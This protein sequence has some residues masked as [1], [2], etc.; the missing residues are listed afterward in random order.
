MEELK[1]MYLDILST[2][3]KYNDSEVYQVRDLKYVAECYIYWSE[4]IEK[5]GF[6]IAPKNMTNIDFMNVGQYMSIGKWGAKYK[7]TIS[8]SDDGRQPEDGEVL[9]QI[10]FPTGAYIFGDEYPSKFF[11][12]FFNELKTYKPKYIDSANKN[13]YYTMGNASEIFNNFKDI[14]NKYKEL[15]KEDCKKR[16]IAKLKEQLKSLEKE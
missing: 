13:L 12:K 8:W 7:R 1:K 4:I 2:L 16:K 9:L 3:K 15:N 6:N 10:C 11:Q 5:Y 14:L